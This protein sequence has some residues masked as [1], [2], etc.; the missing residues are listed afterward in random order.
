[1]RRF[2][3]HVEGLA[4][5]QG[6]P[7]CQGELFLNFNFL[8]IYVFVKRSSFHSIMTIKR[9]EPP[10]WLKSAPSRITPLTPVHAHTKLA[11][12]FVHSGS[13]TTES[14]ISIKSSP[15]RG[16]Q[17]LLIGRL[18]GQNSEKPYIYQFR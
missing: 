12:R 9:R 7:N 5:P 4:G 10:L 16:N 2:G 14:Q 8:V 6:F 13:L 11:D 3:W 1:M 17:I 18:G 15:K